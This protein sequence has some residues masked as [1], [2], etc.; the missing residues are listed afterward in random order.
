MKKI[1]ALLMIMALTISVFTGCKG[2]EA[3]APEAEAI[4][5]EDT[6]EEGTEEVADSTQDEEP[7]VMKV[8]HIQ[9]VEA[10][11]HKTF[12]EFKKAVEE[13]TNGGI[14]VEVYPAAQLGT[15]QE[16]VEAV[17]A[18]TIQGSRG[19]AFE[20]AAPE[21]LL[22]TMPFLFPDSESINKITR[23]PIG[24]KI[25]E[26]SKENNIII[27]ATGVAGGLRNF[28]N[29]AHPITKPEDLE[30]LKMRCP[31]IEV[32]VK[33]MEAL[34]A[35]VASIPYSETYMALKTGVADGE[36][37]PYVFIYDAK[38]YEVQDYLTEVNY[39]IHP[40][41]FYVNLDWFNSLSD[42]Y[43]Q[44][45][46]ECAADMMVS[47]DNMMLADQQS[48]KEIVENNLEITYLTEEQRE[49]F[50]EA[51]QPVYDYYIDQGIFTKDDVNEIRE[52]I[53]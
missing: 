51:V 8:G 24:E 25:A 50:I 18:G 17:K 20:V 12:L 49:V 1:I 36:E 46:K 42:D 48:A 7:I 5:T 19:G 37:N 35:S 23:G 47:N 26:C 21:L 27:L 10:A 43:Q 38:F 41:P 32:T 15:D 30:G 11:R 28:T 40:E 14:V 22:Y 31:P 16:L 13:K 34:G 44:I 2:E 33:T 39:Q 9:P 4:N 52:A 3:S 53:K 6:N 29:N 45:L